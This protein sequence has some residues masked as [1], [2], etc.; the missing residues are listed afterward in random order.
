M[1]WMCWSDG[2]RIRMTV[3]S[4][5]AL[6]ST[7]NTLITDTLTFDWIG[8][9]Q[10]DRRTSEYHDTNMIQCTQSDTTELGSV[11]FS[12]T[13]EWWRHRVHA[14]TY[15][16]WVISE[17]MEARLCSQEKVFFARPELPDVLEDILWN[18]L[19]SSHHLPANKQTLSQS[20]I[21]FWNWI[22][23]F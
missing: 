19:A 21:E 15:L 6:L 10:S 14:K 2:S 8:Y 17:V 9:Y 7:G 3:S 13:A 5:Y 12:N 11:F 23:H 20:R 4:Y 16:G 18:Y 22:V 1:R